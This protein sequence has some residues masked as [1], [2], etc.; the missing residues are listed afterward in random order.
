MTVTDN[1]S[2][3]YSN[4]LWIEKYRPKSLDELI[5]DDRTRNDFVSCMQD[6]TSMPHFLFIGPP[7]TGKTS[8]A[9]IMIDEIIKIQEDVLVLNGSDT[10]GIDTIR[11]VITDF[12][13][14]P[15]FASA[16]KIIFIDE[17]DYLTQ[18]AWAALRHTIERFHEHARFILTANNDTIP[19]PIKSR[20]V[21]LK[22]SA[23]PEDQI[24]N[25]CKK[26]LDNEGVEYSED[27]IKEV[28]RI[29]YPD[30]RKIVGSLQMF[31]SDGKLEITNIDDL[32]DIETRITNMTL[33]YI[34]ALIRND[35][36]AAN[37]ILF[38]LHKTL[39]T[40]YADLLSVCK[41]LF[42][43]LSFKTIPVKVLISKYTQGIYHSPVPSMAY[44]SMLYD[45]RDV[46]SN[47]RHLLRDDE[48][49]EKND[50]H[51]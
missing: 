18:H 46:C 37:Q 48:V 32:I 2:N 4:I 22:F 12:L 19:G 33:D 36:R 29:L 50:T 26:I 21:V 40:S 41:M 16:I 34:K 25:I 8:V 13:R 24:L 1:M 30:I 5:I 42:D 7:G 28:I 11:N 27:S 10:R 17:C 31:S 3:S 43:K 39:S 14:V 20:F 47:I 9:R 15:P 51:T 49:E 23:L 38:T 45:L 44:L 35:Q 6:P